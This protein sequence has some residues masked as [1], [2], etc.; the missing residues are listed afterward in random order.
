MLYD[1]GDGEFLV[2]AEGSTGFNTDNITKTTQLVFIVG[3]VVL[4][5][6]HSLWNPEANCQCPNSSTQTCVFFLYLKD[7]G[8][9]L[10]SNN[11]DLDRLFH[12]IADHHAD[13]VLAHVVLN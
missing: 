9:E 3:K 8:M 7:D 10:L 5:S 11:L 12:G 6:F 13:K 4:V 2:F 1:F